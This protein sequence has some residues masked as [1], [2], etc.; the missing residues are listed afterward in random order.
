MESIPSMQARNKNLTN[1]ANRMTAVEPTNR[2][3]EPTPVQVMEGPTVR[4]LEDYSNSSLFDP[5][6]PTSSA[7]GTPPLTD[8]LDFLAPN[9][10]PEYDEEQAKVCQVLYSHFPSGC[11]RV[12]SDISLKLGR[13]RVSVPVELS[14]CVQCPLLSLW[15]CACYALRVTLL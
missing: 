7:E 2:Q 4:V 9:S 15:Y 13:Y 8:D 3:V 12:G 10:I 1:P 5:I 14:H 11:N 6:E